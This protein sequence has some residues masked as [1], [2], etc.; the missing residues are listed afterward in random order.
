MQSPS[1]ICSQIRSAYM[2][3]VSAVL[4]RLVV[5]AQLAKICQNVRAPRNVG[6]RRHFDPFSQEKSKS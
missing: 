6:G 3:G 4:A 1:G 5:P 2:G